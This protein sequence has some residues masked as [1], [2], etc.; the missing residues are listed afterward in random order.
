MSRAHVHSDIKEVIKPFDWSF[1]TDF[2]GTLLSSSPSLPSFEYTETGLPL[3]L[4]MRR[5]PLLFVGTVD[6]FED[7]LADNG[8][9]ILSVKYRVM[10]DRLLVLSRFFLRLDGVIVRI[11]DTRIVIEFDTGEVLREY[12]E[13]EEKYDAVR[14][15]LGHRPDILSA[16]RQPDLLT[17]ACRIVMTIRERLMLP[18]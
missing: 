13:R 14:S 3:A 8:M 6:L 17:E 9:S 11:R 18:Q 16:M 2:K 15:K 5:D 12:I 1:T 7:E 4:L 10:P